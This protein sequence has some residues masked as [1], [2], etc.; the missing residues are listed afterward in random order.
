MFVAR[1]QGSVQFAHPVAV[2]DTLPQVALRQAGIG[3]K[4]KGVVFGLGQLSGKR[5][6]IRER[7]AQMVIHRQHLA[8]AAFRFPGHAESGYRRKQHGDG[9]DE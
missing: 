5:K 9:K 1:H 2:A 4:R 3:A 6:R 8:G 7:G